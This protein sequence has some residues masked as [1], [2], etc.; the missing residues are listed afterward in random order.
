M[1]WNK[2]SNWKIENFEDDKSGRPTVRRNYMRNEPNIQNYSLK[3]SY[4]D[5]G[6]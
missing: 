6:N 2:C 3:H 5:Y 1:N 4:K